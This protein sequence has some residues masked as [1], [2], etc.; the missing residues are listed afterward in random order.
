MYLAICSEDVLMC[1]GPGTSSSFHGE[2]CGVCVC[3]W[4][5][6]EELSEM[7]SDPPCGQGL[8]LLTLP[9]ISVIWGS[10]EDLAWL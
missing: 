7:S 1:L 4:V 9:H 2:L 6:A 8:L 10:L 3:D 5:S